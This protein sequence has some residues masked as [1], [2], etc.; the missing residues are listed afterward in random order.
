MPRYSLG[1][2]YGTSSCR[3]LLVDLADGSELATAVHP[4]RSG[5]HGV[6]TAADPDLARQEPADYLE[7]LETVALEVLAE[8]KKALPDFR[9]SDIVS[10]G[11][12]TTGS[13]PLPIDASGNALSLLPQFS[14]RLAAKAWLW[15][16]HTAQTT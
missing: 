13:T 14:D 3:A 2:D 16:D 1:I 12:A 5:V 10:I 6:I 8:A 7:G 4:Y 11:F 9:P 15:K